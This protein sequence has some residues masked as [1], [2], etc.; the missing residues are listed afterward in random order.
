MLVA[1][2][3]SECVL[4]KDDAWRFKSHTLR[5]VFMSNETTPPSMVI[6]PHFL[7]EER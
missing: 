6:D 5:P 4:S 7:N 3:I 2:L 1:D